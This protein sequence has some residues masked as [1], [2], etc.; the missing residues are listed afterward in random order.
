MTNSVVYVIDD[1][2]GGITSLTSNLMRFS[3]RH[4]VR[5]TALIVQGRQDPDTRIKE[6]L[7]AHECIPFSYS[8]LENSHA[9]LRRFNRT[10][11]PGPGALVSNSNI[12][13]A[14]YSNRKPD[15]TIFQIVHDD[16]NV[17]LSR[18]YE[19]IIDVMIAHS[20]FI[21]DQLTTEF[22]SRVDSIFYRPYGISLAP[23]VRSP[24]DGPL[25]L[26]FLGR[27]NK[28]KGV[29]DLP[30][31]DRLI[32]AAGVDATWTVIGDGPE[33]ALLQSSWPPSNR[34]TYVTPPSNADVLNICS[35]GDVFVFPTR[36]EGF[37]VALL[38]AMSA[39]LVPVVT[40]LPSGVP[41]VVNDGSGIRVPLGDCPAFAA[42][43]INLRNEPQRL[44]A[45][46]LA[47]RQQAERFRIEDRVQGYLDLF[48]Q[49][50]EFSRPWAGPMKLNHGSRLDKPWI[51]NSL[52]TLLR[53][54]RHKIRS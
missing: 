36:F 13:L 20:R 25:R 7:P 24:K 41:E 14:C 50:Q 2:L 22:P 5:N 54:L 44:N 37:P 42:A 8:F 21:Y 9:L 11:P 39:G 3:S 6:P 52:T 10:V 32:T 23:M 40:D 38:E 16:Y 45:M 47:A 18:R 35:Q 46:S 51:P 48:C 43:I 27:L 1:K 29:H 12:E 33:K 31:I 4:P 53:G 28:G 30:E 34:V 19:P 49:W 17:S 15:R 26:V